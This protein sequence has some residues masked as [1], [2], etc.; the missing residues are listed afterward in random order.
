MLSQQHLQ[1]W[2]YWQ[3][4]E[5]LGQQQQQLLQADAAVAVF[6]F[7]VESAARTAA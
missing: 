7:T 6:S 5:H 1:S 2:R 4:N 3:Q